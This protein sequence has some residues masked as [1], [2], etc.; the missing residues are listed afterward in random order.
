MKHQ[1]LKAP[2]VLTTAMALL[3]SN[4]GHGVEE[5]YALSRSIRALGMGNA[6]YSLSDDESAMFY[7]PAGLSFYDGGAEGMLNL[8]SAHASTSAFSAV[9]KASNWGSASVD[10]IVSDLVEFQGKPV[11]VNATIYPYYLRKHLAVGLL[12]SDLKANASLLGSGIDVDVDVTGISDSGLFVSYGRQLFLPGLHLGLTL[13]GVYRVGGRKTYSLEEVTQ[14]ASSTLT[15]KDLGGGGL[16][17]DAD[18]G[19]I[20]E[21][22]F[23]PLGWDHRVALVFQNLMASNFPWSRI[24]SGGPPPA[25]VR[26]ASLSWM[27]KTPAIGPFEKMNLVVDFADFQWG[28]ETNQ[29]LGA[30]TGAFFKHLNFGGEAFLNNWF[31]VR[32]GFFQGYWCLG[33][34]ITT[35]YVKLD[36]A[37]YATEQSTTPGR[38]G[39]RRFALRLAFGVGS[40]PDAVE[41]MTH[42]S[43]VEAKHNRVEPKWDDSS[44]MEK[45]KAPSKMKKQS[46]GG[47]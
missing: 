22:P 33:A 42:S 10:T 18:L 38:L 7:N 14:S 12:I 32:A 30:R 27:A 43:E 39:S 26:T 45:P 34:G 24:S 46:D 13:K 36:A 20:Y 15:L 8:I 2:L 21:L 40:A 41:P 5:W 44:K 35:N 28:G 6:F 9:S 4:I 3:F 1:L 11:D 37:T 31:A 47:I 23:R 16:G 29:Q 25:L 19:A 17:V